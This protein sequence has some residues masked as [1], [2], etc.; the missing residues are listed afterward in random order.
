M[1]NP[2]GGRAGEPGPGATLGP[3]H[4]VARLGQGAMGTVYRARDA[5]G[6]EV[7]L[8]VIASEDASNPTFVERF[9]RESAAAAS[10]VHPH[11]A[12]CLGS[13][14]AAGRLYL[15]LE[16]VPGGTLAERLHH[17]GRLPWRETVRLGLEIA[18]AL[19]AVHAAGL[20][21]RD[22]K[23]QNVLLEVG[24][25]SAAHGGVGHAKLADFGI[26]RGVAEANKL[27]RTG[28]VLGSAE[29]MAPEQAGTSAEVDA[30]ADLYALG[31]TLFTLVAGEAPF[32]GSLLTVLK[33]KLLEVAPRLSSRETTVPPALDALVA[34]LLSASPDDRPASARA[35]REALAAILGQKDGAALRR[36]RVVAGLALFAV[37][38]LG[39]AALGRRG[40]KPVPPVSVAPTTPGAG[41][42]PSGTP[43][44]TGVTAP[45]L[46]RWFESLEPRPELPPGVRPMTATGEYENET[47]HS[48]LLYVPAG[49]FRMGRDGLLEGSPRPYDWTEEHPAHDVEL[50]A[51][52]LG[53]LE[54]SNDEFAAFCRLAPYSTE[55]ERGE[56][57]GNVA[58]VS[59]SG[60]VGVSFNTVEGASW[61]RP[62]GT[63]AALGD[64]PVCQV[65]WADASAYVRWAGLRLPTEAEWERA[66]SWDGSKASRYPWGDDHDGNGALKANVFAAGLEV[67]AEPLRP[68]GKAG[69]DRS[70]IGALHMCGNVAEWVLDFASS[71]YPAERKD[72]CILEPLPGE[73]A[74]TRAC[75]GGSFMNEW[76]RSRCAFR[77]VAHGTPNDT[78]GFRVAL[79]AG[80]PR[81][82]EARLP[83][84]ARAPAS[85]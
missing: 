60:D 82:W 4:L 22:L 84:A 85:H 63:G 66:A 5:S 58:Q 43:P 9:R 76:D 54:V 67:V 61:K 79:S 18:S 68:V 64:R 53:K 12:R 33:R 65:T 80:R 31:A 24:D 55:V 78:I 19:E 8:K 16:L 56:A 11:V 51:Y 40:D 6:A 50:S 23:P 62:H 57:R 70:P 28:E 2:V 20:V 71:H 83:G 36:T 27:T 42:K 72:P 47:D 35:V 75:K 26:A 25:G 7:A 15:A 37:A 46:P 14:E 48:V 32:T 69:A 29:Y 17:A 81:E 21:H 44:T 39:A 45:P 34:S 73:A 38:G 3:Y 49:T 77:G 59:L 30:R 13:G 1:S 10:V 41:A 74:G 52:F